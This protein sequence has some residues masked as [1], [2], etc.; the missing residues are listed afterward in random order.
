[1][2]YKFVELPNVEAIQKDVLDFV[3]SSTYD[4]EPNEDHSIRFAQ[5]WQ[6]IS[7]VVHAVETITSWEHVNYIAFA[8]SPPRTF[9]VN[10]HQDSQSDDLEYPW[11]LN[12][13]IFNCVQSYVR[14]YKVKSNNQSQLKTYGKDQYQY[15]CYSYNVHDLE[16]KET[17]RLDKPAFFNT[18][19][20]H[21]PINLSPRPRHIISVRFKIDLRKLNFALT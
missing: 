13:P 2:F 14:F 15:P 18:R 8:T 19:E 12:I 21:S 10:P 20:I 9:D 11:A 16:I 1:M 5:T 17:V 3:R 7:S 6:H 4:L